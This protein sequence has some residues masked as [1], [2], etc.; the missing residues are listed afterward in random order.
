[1]STTDGAIDKTYFVCEID[2]LLSNTEKKI[3]QIKHLPLT[4]FYLSL[5][6][7]I[8]QRNRYSSIINNLKYEEHPHFVTNLNL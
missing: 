7:Q 4:K 8:K 1:M 5:S 6:A 3:M 2:I